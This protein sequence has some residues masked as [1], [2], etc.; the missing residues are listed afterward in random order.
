MDSAQ[1]KKTPPKAF[2]K[3]ERKIPKRI[4]ADYL[5][6]SGLYYLQRFAASRAGFEKVMLRKV[7]KSCHH[8]TDQNYQDCVLMV[9]TV[10][11][12]FE[13]AGL[14][15]DTVF[16]RGLAT[17]L[18]RAGKS[19]KAVRYKMTLKGL[20]DEIAE[21]ALRTHDEEHHAN[22]TEADIKAAVILARRKKMG[23]FA[24]ADHDKT[25]RMIAT[26]ARAGFSYGIAQKIL[27]M[28]LSDAEEILDS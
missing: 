15:N 21:S 8:H 6:N 20:P 19:S 11:D 17:S 12:D 16:A 9:R 10:A 28:N 27:S 3:K 2:Q 26:L 7:K 4:T 1:P 23:P 13:R 22:T 24:P 25:E 14:L 5:R 18:R